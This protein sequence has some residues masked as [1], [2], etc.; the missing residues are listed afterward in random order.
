[1]GH[2]KPDLTVLDLPPDLI[3]ILCPLSL[4]QHPALFVPQAGRFTMMLRFTLIS[5]VLCL[6]SMILIHVIFRS[7][8]NTN[9]LA[10]VGFRGGGFFAVLVR[11]SCVGALF[12]LLVP[13]GSGVSRGVLSRG[14]GGG[15]SRW[16]G[17][18]FLAAPRFFLG[19]VFPGCFGGGWDEFLLPPRLVNSMMT[20]DSSRM[21][22]C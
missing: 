7:I 6:Y 22:V 20:L 2:V 4:L 21:R 10:G 12:G 16:G 13:F 15:R 8:I 19:G 14:G 17:V 11:F 18:F 5:S 9:S 1:M 3:V